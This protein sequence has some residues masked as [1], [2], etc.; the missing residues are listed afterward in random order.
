M[1]VALCIDMT[2]FERIKIGKKEGNNGNTKTKQQ[3]NSPDQT[4]HMQ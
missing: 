1:G 3:H 4:A 2:S